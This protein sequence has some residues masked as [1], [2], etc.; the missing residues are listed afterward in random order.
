MQR[1]SG[2]LL[3]GGAAPLAVEEE[4]AGAERVGL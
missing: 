1:R 2:G 4:V 3:A